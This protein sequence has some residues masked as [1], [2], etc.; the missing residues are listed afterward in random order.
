M[1]VAL[2]DM[3]PLGDRPLFATGDGVAELFGRDVRLIRDTFSTASMSAGRGRVFFIE[4]AQEVPNYIV[5][6]PRQ[7]GDDAWWGM[8][9]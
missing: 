5:H 4:P 1:V 7:D 9:Y 2:I 3:A 6:D 8:D